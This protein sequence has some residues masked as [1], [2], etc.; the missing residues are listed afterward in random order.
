MEEEV[1]NTTNGKVGFTA[2]D[3]TF[4]AL[5]SP[6]ID[7]PEL[8]NTLYKHHIDFDKDMPKELVD[9]K[10]ELRQTLAGQHVL[11][12]YKKHR[13]VPLMDNNNDDGG[14]DSNMDM[15]TTEM[16]IIPKVV[17]RNQLSRE[18]KLILAMLISIGTVMKRGSC[19]FRSNL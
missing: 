7:P 8:A 9:L 14:G 13:L 15:H 17:N 18:V 10:Y 12:M 19:W 4:A 11:Q 6:I 5:A 2:A 3:L 16:M 1:H